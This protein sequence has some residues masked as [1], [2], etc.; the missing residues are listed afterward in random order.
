[1]TLS[2]DEYEARLRR[3]RFDFQPW[4]AIPPEAAAEQKVIHAVLARVGKAVLHPSAYIA[5]NAEVHTDFL[6]VGRD[7]AIAGGAVLRGDIRIGAEC[8]VNSYAVIAGKVVIGS[9]VRIAQSVSIVGFNHNFYRLDIDIQAQGVTLKGIRIGNDVWIGANAVILDGVTVGAH[10]IVAAGAVVTRDVA[11]WSIV[12]GNPARLLRDRHATA[13]PGTLDAFDRRL[14][15]EMRQVTGRWLRR[16]DSGAVWIAGPEGNAPLLAPVCDALELAAMF[17]LPCPGQE[18]DL[19]C[20]SLAALQDPVSGL[21]SDRLALPAPEADAP[22]AMPDLHLTIRLNHAL[23]AWGSHLPHPLRAG[24]EMDEATLISRLEALDWGERA[25]RAGDWVDNLA[26]ALALNARHFGDDRLIAPL[27]HWLDA[28]C[29]P[30]TGLWGSATAKERLR[31]PVNGSYRIVRGCYLQFARPLPHPEALIDTLLTHVTDHR[32]FDPQT[33]MATDVLDVVHLLHAATRQTAHR[34]DEVE[35]WLRGWLVPVMRQWQARRGLPMNLSVNRP[36]L[37]GTE[38]WLSALWAMA[39]M[40]A[41][42]D[43]LSFRP[44][45]LH[46]LTPPG[47]C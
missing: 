14:R 35:V 7:S 20:R 17:N 2:E 33:A 25:W 6:A 36:G 9:G 12:G 23:E 37:Q 45:G 22:P 19:W 41:L 1:M 30:Q 8:S 11:P 31:Q 24:V 29:D 47:A 46:R 34:R 3:H 13:L 42:S 40:L 38:M 16:D 10:S 15:N 18:A 5:R 26:S 28:R 43:H 39:G 44:K 21:V 4:G 27:L 32:L